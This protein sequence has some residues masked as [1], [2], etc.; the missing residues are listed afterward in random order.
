MSKSRLALY[1]QAG[2]SSDAYVL[3]HLGLVKRVAMH[4]HTRV[5][6]F[7]EMDDL[8]QAGMLG[9]IQASRAFDP[10]KGFPF[11]GF[12]YV[13][14]KGAMFD[15]IRKL[16]YL[17]RSAVATGKSH[18]QSTDELSS[19]LGRA[20]SHSELAAFMNK[21]VESL[22][23]ERAESVRFQTTSIETLPDSV[24]NIAA[25]DSMRPDVLVENAQF[26]EALEEA[27]NGLPQR[28][29]LIIS[30]YYVEELNL[31]EI[32]SVVDVSESRVSQILSATAKVL[33]KTLQ[34]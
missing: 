22:H 10:A 27:I 21:D 20:P 28:E 13:R 8:L 2:P 4:L 3:E 17:P 9:L 31:A 15:E 26:M 5:P 29:K 33:R 6:R 18:A 24:E 30:L 25:D 1:D 23:K 34:L 19:R 14:V 16:S 11:E 7:I 12:A 32:G